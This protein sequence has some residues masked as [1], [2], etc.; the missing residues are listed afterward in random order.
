MIYHNIFYMF[1]TEIMQNIFA[2]LISEYRSKRDKTDD[3]SA[4]T[5]RIKGIN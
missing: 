1:F 4:K 3:I 5:D 2:L